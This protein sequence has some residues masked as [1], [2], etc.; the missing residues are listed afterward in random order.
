MDWDRET[1]TGSETEGHQYGQSDK[2]KVRETGTE[3]GTEM[4]GQGRRNWS[5]FTLAFK[6]SESACT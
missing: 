3:M 6:L 5:P 1:R 4:E 2:D